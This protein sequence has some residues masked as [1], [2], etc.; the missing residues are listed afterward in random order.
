MNRRSPR[1]KALSLEPLKPPSPSALG[2]YPPSSDGPRYIQ[3]CGLR[4]S[5]WDRPSASSRLRSS[6]VRVSVHVDS[7]SHAQAA[8][9]HLSVHIY[10]YIYTYTHTCRHACMHV[11]VHAYIH[12]HAHI[13]GILH[14]H[15]SMNKRV[16]LH[17]CMCMIQHIYIQRQSIF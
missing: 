10:I 6:N 3:L 8:V 15:K 4:C 16:Y 9:I 11:Y 12:T 2:A 5:T 17:V 1:P 14:T 7:L 13:H